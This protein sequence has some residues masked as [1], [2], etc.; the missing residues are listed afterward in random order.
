MSLIQITKSD[1]IFSE[2]AEDLK[3]LRSDFDN[4]HYIRLPELLDDN[5]LKVV[6]EKINQTK[7]SEINEKKYGI[8]SVYSRIKDK[9][10]K[11]IIQFLLND[12]TLF[13]FIEKVTGCS[14]IGC[15]TGR[16]YCMN[17]A[18]GHYDS[19]HNDLSENR[20]IAISINLSTEIYS[21]GTLQ[22]KDLS[23]DKIVHEVANTGFGDAIIFQIAPYLN[24]RLTEV[25]GEFSR[26][27]FAGWFRSS[28]VY[29]PI[30]KPLEISDLCLGNKK[31]LSVS[32][33]SIVQ[34]VEDLY[35][36]DASEKSLVF[37][38]KNETCYGLDSIGGEILTMIKR[39]MQISEIKNIILN[40]YDVEEEKCESDL[41][42][43]IQGL[44]ASDI[45]TVQDKI[46][47]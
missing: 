23:S 5:L 2:Q 27:F 32:I 44:E 33:D 47:I 34:R 37:N 9:T 40:E 10:I 36:R 15:F 26:T 38:P 43:L 31:E 7:L 3:K 39:P 20:M 12:Q 14:T 46:T 30:F 13:R 4:K 18:Y 28:P 17:P 41:I 29:K 1:T 42:S 8:D 19:W 6:W 21:G 16:I 22:I 24:H 25:T 45:I 35:F 11:G